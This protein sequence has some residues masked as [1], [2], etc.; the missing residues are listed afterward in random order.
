MRKALK[1]VAWFLAI[2]LLGSVATLGLAWSWM[3]RETQ[4]TPPGEPRYVRFDSRTS[5]EDALAR[6]ETEG[7]VRNARALL[8]YARYRRDPGAVPTGTY[9][10][11]PGMDRDSLLRTL[12]NPIRRMVRL[13]AHFWIARTAALLEEH[14]V[15]T[16]DEYIALAH[17]PDRFRDVVSFPLP[18]DSLEGYLFPDTYDLPPLLGAEGVIR[19]QLQTFERK[20]YEALGRPEDLHRAVII[21]SMVQLEAAL[22]EERARIAGVIENRLRIRM[23]LQ[24]D[25]TVNYGMQEWR[26]LTYRDYRE[27][28]SPFNTYRVNGLPPGPICSPT[29]ASIRG[30]LEPETHDYL[31]YVAM[32]ERHH[33]FSRTY[34]EHLRNVQRRRAAIRALE[35]GA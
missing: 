24:I 10:L 32:P 29:V 19:R 12:R 9:E 15:C 23:R 28:D 22:D 8:I 26:P 27:V 13:P 5:L 21:G 35:G 14:E 2:L 7:F 31:F 11:S 33:L 34:E 17:D 4:P 6:L 25:A 16:A 18:D 30:A 1:F 3:N 20:V